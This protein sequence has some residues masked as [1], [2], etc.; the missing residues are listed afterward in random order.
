[1][2]MRNRLLATVG[3][4]STSKATV[5]SDTSVR[6][7]GAKARGTRVT[8]RCILG[9]LPKSTSIGMWMACSPAGPSSSTRAFSSVV[10]PT[11]AYGQRSRSHMALK[12]GSS[13][14]ATAIT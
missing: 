13:S 9:G 11:T 6:F 1:M 2:V 5:S 8:S 12:T 7:S 14:G 10:T 4:R 3:W